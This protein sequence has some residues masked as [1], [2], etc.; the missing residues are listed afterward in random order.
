MFVASTLKDQLEEE[1]GTDSIKALEHKTYSTANELMALEQLDE[2][3]KINKRLLNRE[4]MVDDALEWLKLGGM[5]KPED[6]KTNEESE[7]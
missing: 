7:C 2:L 4:S 1:I 3:R 5:E 6:N